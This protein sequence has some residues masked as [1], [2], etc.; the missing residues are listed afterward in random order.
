AITANQNGSL[1]AQLKYLNNQLAWA[2]SSTD[3]W[4]LNSGNVGIGTSSPA[5][6]LDVS[7]NASV[8]GTFEAGTLL[9]DAQGVTLARLGNS[10][11]KSLQDLQNFYHSSGLATGGG[12][13]DVGG[14]NVS[15]TAGTGA[16]R[17]SNAALGT[18]LW[19]DF[20]AS[21][22]INIPT[23][24]VRYLGVSYNSGSPK[25]FSRDVDSFNNKTE[26]PLG[27]VVNEGGT[28]IIQENAFAPGDHA[29]NMV[30]R[31][32][33]TMPLEPDMR[34]GGLML[35]EGV[36]R[37]IMVSAGVLW[38]RLNRY[39][40]AAI[41]TSGGDTFETYYRDGSGGFVRTLG[42]SQWPNDKYDNN[43]GTLATLGAGKFGVL[44]FYIKPNGSLV[45]VYGRD[46]HGSSR[47]AASEAAPATDT[48][49]DSV[50]VQSRLL[51]RLIFQ[52]NASSASAAQ[53]AFE[54]TFPALFDNP[55]IAVTENGTQ[56]V[57]I[58]SLSF[59]N[60]GFDV[61]NPSANVATV[62]LDYTNGPAS[63]SIAQNITGAWTFSGA[64]T[65]LSISNNASASG[66]FEAGTL[67][68]GIVGSDAGLTISPTSAFHL[69]PG[70]GLTN[71]TGIASL[72]SN[73]YALGNVGIGTTSPGAALNIAGTSGSYLT[74][75]ILATSA[76]GSSIFDARMSGQVSIGGDIDND[77]ALHVSSITQTG[78]ANLSTTGSSTTVTTTGGAFANVAESARIDANGVTRYVEQKVDSNTII[79]DEVVD[80]S[81]GYAFTYKNPGFIMADGA[82]SDVKGLAI[83]EGG[84]PSWQLYTWHDEA[85]EFFYLWNQQARR[86]ILTIGESGVVGVNQP[87]TLTG[88]QTE[89]PALLALYPQAYDKVFVYINATATYYDGTTGAATSEDTPTAFP[90]A[91]NTDFIYLGMDRKAGGSF[92]ERVTGPTV[93]VLKAE[94]WNGATW[95]TITA[96]MGYSDE[97]NGFTKSGAVRWNKDALTNWAKT[98]VNSSD[99]YYWVRFSFTTYIGSDQVRANMIVPT[100]AERLSAYKA[101]N[102]TNPVFSVNSL[103]RVGLGDRVRNTRLN[104]LSEDTPNGAALSIIDTS[105][106]VRIW[107]FGTGKAG[108][109]FETGTSSVSNNLAW[110]IHIASKAWANGAEGFILEH[111]N[112]EQHVLTLGY[113]DVNAASRTMAMFESPFGDMNGND[114]MRGL[115]LN[116]T[117]GAH[118][119][120]GNAV[121]GLDIGGMTP[122]ANASESAIFIGSGWDYAFVASQGNVGIGTLTPGYRLTVAG[123]ASVSQMFGAGLA[124]CDATSDILRWTSAT[125]AF[126]CGSAST[127]VDV[128]FPIHERGNP[129]IVAASLSFTTSGFTVTDLSG[130]AIV[131][132]DY[133]NGPASR[134]IAQT[135]TGAWN[136]T[137]GASVSSTLEAVG[138]L[139]ASSSFF[140][141]GLT[142]CNGITQ[143]LT[144]AGGQFG[145]GV[146]QDTGGGGGGGTIEVREYGA[147]YDSFPATI[148]FDAGKFSLTASNGTDVTV[149]LDWGAGGP[150]SL[151]QNE[152]VTG[153][154]TFSGLM[155]I[156]NASVSS[157]LEI[158]GYASVSKLFG[159][160]I[161]TCTGAGQ[162]LLYN[163]TTGVFSC[164]TE[165]G[166]GSWNEGTT[167]VV[168]NPVDRHFDAGAFNLVASGAT[169][170]AVYLDYANGPASRSIAQTI[171]GAW[172]FTGGA[173][174][175]T[176]PFEVGANV[177]YAN[178]STG[179]VGVNTQSLT[180]ALEVVG[181]ASVSGALY[182]G[183]MGVGQASVA[184]G[185]LLDVNGAAMVGNGTHT[186]QIGLQFDVGHLYTMHYT[187]D[188]FGNATYDGLQ[189]SGAATE[190]N[191]FTMYGSQSVQFIANAQGNTYD[192]QVIAMSNPSMASLG[193][194]SQGLFTNKGT[195]HDI[196][197]QYRYGTGTPIDAILID[198]NPTANS[199]NAV[200]VNNDNG[201]VPFRVA[202]QN[203][204]NLLYVNGSSRIGVG[205]NAPLT[206]LEVQGTASASH[207]LTIGGLQVGNGASVAYSRFGSATTGHSLSAAND[208]LISG[209]LETDGL[210]FFD[211]GASVSVGIE[212]SGFASASQ[213]FGA[214]LTTCT[215]TFNVLRY[216]AVTGL[217]SC[218][219]E[220]GGLRTEL[221][222]TTVVANNTNVSFDSGKFTL[223]A[224]GTTETLINLAWG[225]GGPASLSQDEIVTGAWTFSGL[226]S[227]ANASSSGTIEA[228]AL[229]TDSLTSSVGTL[230]LGAFR[231]NGTVTGNNQSMTGLNALSFVSA[232]ASGTLEAISLRSGTLG[233]DAGMSIQP[234][235]QLTLSPGTSFT[236]I[237]G[238]A[239]LSGNFE[240]TS[241]TAR[242]GIN[243]GV[244]T[245]AMLEVGGTASIGS[246]LTLNGALSSAFTASNSFAGSIEVSKGLRARDLTATGA[247]A[248][249]AFTG[250]GTNTISSTGTLVLGAYTLGGAV[251]GNGQNITGLN[252]LT[253]AF[254]SASGVFEA[255]TLKATTIGGD[256][257]LT[258]APTTRT[259][260]TG[261]AS[262]STNF[263]VSGYASASQVLGAGLRDC[264]DV[265]QK[266]L[267]TASGS[268][269]GKFSCGYDQSANNVQVFT[270]GAAQTWTRPASVSQVYVEVWGAGGGGRTAGANACGGGGGGGGYSAGLVTVTG[271]A[272]VN[273]GTGG[274]ANTT[275]GNSSFA[276]TTT[277]TGNGGSSPAAGGA[278]G[279]GGAASGGTINI[280]GGSGA[281]VSQ[282]DGCMGGVGGGSPMGG[283]GGGAGDGGSANGTNSSIGGTAGT[284]PGGGGGG[285]N[286]AAGAGGSGADGRVI[287]WAYAGT[288]RADVAEWYETDGTVGPGD[289]V[290]MGSASLTYTSETG[291]HTVAVLTKAKP[292]DTIFGV[293]STYPE[294]YMGKD[295]LSFAK[296][297]QPIAL[298]GR[299][300]VNVSSE[301][302][303]IRKGDI[304]RLSGT[305]GVAALSNKAGQVIGAALEDF[306]GQPGEAGKVLV[307]VQ[308][309]YSTGARLKD[310]MRRQGLDM[311]AI[312]ENVDVGRVL[313]A[314]AIQE[315]KSFTRETDISDVFTDRVMAGLE[316]V[317]PRVLADTA[318]VNTIEGSSGDVQIRL[319]E[320]GKLMLVR[321]SSLSSSFGDIAS[322]SGAPFISFDANGNAVISGTL[323]VG[324]LDA[325][326][327]A[328]WAD[329]TST[330]ATLSFN[331]DQL[332]KD[333]DAY[334][335]EFGLRLDALA[336]AAAAFSFE[337]PLRLPNGLSIDSIGAISTALN[338]TSDTIFLGRPYFNS[339]TAGF[340]VIERGA[341]E[342]RV[343]F[344]SEYLSQPVVMISISEEASESADNLFAA[345]YAVVAKDVT[346]FTIRVAHPVESDL[347]FSWV[348]LAVNNAK[349]FHSLP[350]TPTPESTPTSTEEATPTATPESTPEEITT[351]PT[352]ES[353]PTS[354]E[355]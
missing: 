17:S 350:V 211:A 299:V 319:G 45:M 207:L 317:A 111:H 270:A 137:G 118:S 98:S 154:W 314:Q 67:R 83:G 18:I 289:I 293:V 281:T 308:T 109:E 29:A 343:T 175:S 27:N 84:V 36:G 235:G 15:V 290:A 171:T 277:P 223:T 59:A 284:V 203:D 260:I 334:R 236:Q 182:A 99:D 177:L 340:A 256:G 21:T 33:E 173:S 112:T 110:S 297:P 245:D 152:T 184:Q 345:P 81:G 31:E 5:T 37:T 51:G 25:V 353:T 44:W 197:I 298:A 342:V 49:P 131:G 79:V 30:Q 292:G 176:N 89:S 258:L 344:D 77:A 332:G 66:I 97:T 144:W 19:F 65:G 279:A 215:G 331:L 224:S 3:I 311:E 321:A 333:V 315:K 278:G 254:G 53:S 113:T 38:D 127:L 160:A 313:L 283:A 231:L 145:C 135:I 264:D 312:P 265:N 229:K 57:S 291:T 166:G 301:Y 323:Q 150:A 75:A 252:N 7:G 8:S 295:I 178:P 248:G 330:V 309:S 35:D 32:Y 124:D 268:S 46:E 201:N 241:A 108:L 58:V 156:A 121:R 86:D 74:S 170:V 161:P 310:V 349:T 200:I 63:R 322:G 213:M 243:A 307:L 64:G 158:T 157:G 244:L 181:N 119:G 195:T 282:T 1:I 73:L 251:T 12:I 147:A 153:A 39:A 325:K 238:N 221:D 54:S 2:S 225:A 346:G 218:G 6:K 55:G 125:G 72:S 183:S 122:S 214:G 239:S 168:A 10:T 246:T 179:R 206:K 164:T 328:G 169:D 48:L 240:L 141:A 155:G 288:S 320:N 274:G 220:G 105:G 193:S 233:A 159:S 138:D 335:D 209:R 276:G 126:S 174:V 348:A 88:T 269:A 71:I 275:G 338:L 300:P 351:T 259:Q 267:W 286:D 266:L 188:Q 50:R 296:N 198:A 355:E 85:S 132:I 208:V 40:I 219:V 352:P 92:V 237:N 20:P 93:G 100:A 91:T 90:I 187:P 347:R 324:Y 133:A 234:V 336:S 354:T 96:G 162:K 232:S 326:E 68:A 226:T 148:S 56:F 261:A 165:V 62:H 247:G 11:F 114:L 24:S 216:S 257:V 42:V 41:D 222:Q 263:E 28:L 115:Y 191:V 128:P 14:G 318:V 142:D 210:A 302:G 196:A 47:Q 13:S 304:L 199:I 80:W 9:G 228:T 101:L 102:D 117:N 271:N 280:T 306:S 140:G 61:T 294:V 172:N 136:F 23:D 103:G 130:D 139:Y 16:I 250:G 341:R 163:G 205:T 116:Y 189:I 22:S 60:S 82:S 202:G 107:N 185:F 134:S 255:L 262:I 249:L 143:K 190:Q 149:S 186:K 120:S 76:S 287:V 87:T 26:F 106:M 285:G 339:D 43:S 129:Y 273:V 78:A 123:A 4:N 227:L 70:S 194:A 95:T 242:F 192:S 151:S 217:F 146:D 329:L 167:S 337:G 69:S 316:V 212:S 327:V 34:S 272:T 104:D 94:Y 303:A 230:D 305:P 52:K 180:E 253:L 204:A